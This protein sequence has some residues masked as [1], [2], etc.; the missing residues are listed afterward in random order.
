MEIS[1]EYL[2]EEQA[3]LIVAELQRQQPEPLE[4]TDYEIVD[5]YIKNQLSVLE[6]AAKQQQALEQLNVTPEEIK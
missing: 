2:N 3:A 6:T 4:G 1:K 5:N